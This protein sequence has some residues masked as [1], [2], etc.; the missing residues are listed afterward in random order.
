MDYTTEYFL[1]LVESYLKDKNLWLPKE[2][3]IKAAKRATYLF[4]VEDY[5]KEENAV[6]DAVNANK[7]KLKNFELK[8]SYKDGNLTINYLDGSDIESYEAESNEEIMDIVE[9]AIKTA[10]DF[11]EDFSHKLAFDGGK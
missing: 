9:D 10:V 4:T 3:Q 6:E 1:R 5:S 7:S 8:I 11:E 2:Q